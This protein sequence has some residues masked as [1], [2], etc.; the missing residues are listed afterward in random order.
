L[1]YFFVYAQCRNVTRAAEVLSISQPSLSQQ[2]KIFEAEVGEALFLRQ[3]RSI[4]LSHK[5]KQLYESSK[6]LFEI[7]EAISG[8]LSPSTKDKQ[9]VFRIGVSPEIER[10]FIAEVVGKILKTR[11]GQKT[12]FEVISK[13]IKEITAD[14][15][16]SKIE[17]AIT[18]IPIRDR[19]PTHEFDFP[20][21]LTTSH[22]QSR[23]KHIQDDNLSSVFLTL[24]ESLIVPSPEILLRQELDRFL[25]KQQHVPPIVF[26][27]NILACTVRA[28]REK[29][30]CGFLPLPYIL[31]EFKR[32]S[33]SIIGPSKGYWNHRVLFYANSKSDNTMVKS[34]IQVVTESITL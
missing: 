24:E 1:Y 10:P 14:L 3:G 2:L 28:I 8:S 11:R 18:N 31:E 5:G 7:A 20:V 33:I 21:F 13:P 6:E 26:E 9:S 25:A 4:E 23:F 30:G 17:L 16:A 19:K 12:R 15:F 22:H 29:I 32:G 34:M 27:S